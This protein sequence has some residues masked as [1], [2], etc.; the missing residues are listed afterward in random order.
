MTNYGPNDPNQPYDPN[1]KGSDDAYGQHSG[2]HSGQYGQQNDG[3]YGQQNDGQ[4][5]QQGG[6]YGA[7]A[8]GYNPMPG[9]GG[10]V[11]TPPPNNLA[12]PLGIVAIIQATK[13]NSLWAQG[14]HAGA[15]EASEKAK[16]FSIWSAIAGIV[17]GIIY[18][19]LMFTILKDSNA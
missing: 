14:D 2:Q 17:F 12:I 13:V 11:G 15:R 7:G 9:D 5:G 6:Q 3:Q 4:Y 19:I 8:P 18:A 16:K 1:N 10:A